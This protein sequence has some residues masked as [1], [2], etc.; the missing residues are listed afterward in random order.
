[1]KKFVFFLLLLFSTQLFVWATQY[2][3]SGTVPSG[4]TLF[5]KIGANGVSV[6]SQYTHT[7]ATNYDTNTR[8]SGNLVIPASISDDNTSYAV[9]GIGDYAFRDCMG[10]L[11]VTIPNTVTSIGRQAFA[12]CNGLTSVSIP[13]SVASINAAFV[14]CR[15]LTTVTLP[16]SLISIDG[17]FA[18]CS[19]LTSIDIPSTVTSIG[20]MTFYGCTSLNSVVIPST[21]TAI[22][23]N[24]FRGCVNLT[25][26]V[27]ENGN[28]VYDSRNGCNAIIVTAIDL[29][30]KGCN[31]TVIP[32]TV[33]SIGDYALAGC[34]G[35]ESIVVP[36][37]VTDIG[38]GAFKDCTDL[39]HVEIQGPVATLNR[40]VFDGC[41]RLEYVSLPNT[42][43]SIYLNA[44]RNCTGIDSIV[45]NAEVPPTLL[46]CYSDD[47]LYLK[48]FRSNTFFVPCQ[49]YQIYDELWVQNDNIPYGI[50]FSSDNNNEIIEQSVDLS[51][52]LHS[53]DT[54]LGDVG[55]VLQGD[56]EINCADSSSI[57]FAQP[58]PHCHFRHWSNGR[59][60]NP[61]T[62]FLMGDS[63]VTAFFALDTHSV[64]LRGNDSIAILSGE[65]T[66]PYG[67]RAT[68]SAT[69][70]S[71][72]YSFA[73]WNV[74]DSIA[75]CDTYYTF[76]VTG[77]I[78]LT[79]VFIENNIN[80][81]ETADDVDVRIY[82]NPTTGKLIIEVVD[83]L[84]VKVYDQE[85]KCLAVYHDANNID[86]SGL[87]VGIYLL[88]IHTE[89][90]EVKRRVVRL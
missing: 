24:A 3:F 86:L 5:F 71:P 88:G 76:V 8:P 44:F 18:G 53:N 77:D 45:V 15:N 85:G 23:A 43:L 13:S 11:S 25:S 57:I 12:G 51:L 21:V 32:T 84:Y 28:M 49:T 6:V 61:D 81:V 34:S 70:V 60:S 16:N 40:L 73:S 48:Q 10:L 17:A 75:S 50:V 80:D 27:V 1:M 67:S 35:I 39:G 78:E 69:M 9:V 79:A 30:I 66:Y 2:D 68:V 52:I 46:H 37:S 4:Q 56:D 47:K 82:P 59:T 90:Y 62:L 87:P 38:E 42:V 83:F 36:Q 55:I 63:I 54:S 89:R 29:L 33:S 7:S 41:S 14:G 19:S 64:R 74:G 26:I 65:G 20:F 72:N 31:A 58:N 22:S